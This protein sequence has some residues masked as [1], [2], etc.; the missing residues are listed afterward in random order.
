M[1]EFLNFIRDHY[2]VLIDL[3]LWICVL[4]VTL[5]RKK[6][7]IKDDFSSVLLVLPDLIKLAEEKFSVGSEKYSF[8]FNKC[9]EMLASL[10]HRSKES[11]ICDYTGEIDA[12]IENILATPQKKER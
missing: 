9:V 3:V 2:H 10:S 8:V 4:L 6:V 11:V 7:K 5:L 12:A 1:S